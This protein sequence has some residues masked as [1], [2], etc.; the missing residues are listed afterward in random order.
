MF[1]E[2]KAA[3]TKNAMVRLSP[4]EYLVLKKAA[5]LE[6]MTPSAYIR[7]AIYRQVKQDLPEL[8]TQQ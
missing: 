8:V 1:S 7:Q 4:E 3:R 5:E 2:P 6:G